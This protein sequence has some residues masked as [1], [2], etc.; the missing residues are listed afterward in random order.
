MNEHNKIFF[1]KLTE[2][3]VCKISFVPPNIDIFFVFFKFKVYRFRS[4]QFNPSV[5]E[6]S[7]PVSTRTCI[8]KHIPTIK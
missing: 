7:T 1:I 5:V 8:P 3:F 6:F 2:I 4:D